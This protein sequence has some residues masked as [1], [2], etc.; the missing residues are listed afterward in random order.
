MNLAVLVASDH[1]A[2]HFNI[3][4]TVASVLDVTID[5]VAQ[6]NIHGQVRCRSPVILRVKMRPRRAP[7]LL[8]TPDAVLGCERIAKQEIGEGVAREASI[9]DKRAARI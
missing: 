5:L 4:Q 8:P 9:K 6:P 3:R 1:K 2:T 7:V